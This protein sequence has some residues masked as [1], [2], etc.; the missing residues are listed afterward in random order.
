MP[1]MTKIRESLGTFFLVFSVLF[2]VYMVLDWGMDITGRRR[3]DRTQSQEIGKVNGHEI[4]VK[5]FSDLVRRAADNQK[6]QTGSEPDEDQLKNIREQVWN[7]LV[8]DILYE[9]QIKR[10]GITVT[11][12]EIIDW[13][14]GNDPPAFLKQQFTDSTGT[15]NRQAYD[16][17][18][19]DPKNKAIMVSIESSLRKQREREKLQ[20]LVTTSIQT[21]E[22]EIRQRFIDQN[23][24]FNAGFLY[25]DPNV[26]VKDD[27]VKVTDDDLRRFYN[28]HSDEFKV[29]ATRK[30]KYIMFSNAPSHGDSESVVSALDDV[31]KRVTE[32]ADFLDLAKQ[33]SETPVSDTYYKHGDLPQDQENAIFAAKDGEILGPI[34]TLDGYHLIKVL[35]FRNG[36]NTAVHASHIL[37]SIQNN[38]SVTAL[39][40]AKDV[41]AQAKSGKDFAALAKQ[42]SKDPGSAARGGDV[43]WFGKGKMVPPFEQAAFKAGAGQ[44][45]GPVR[46]QFGYH[47]IKVL[48]KDS[49]EVKIAD[50]HMAVHMSSQTQGDISQRAQDFIYLAKQGSFEK[51]AEQSK[52][53]VQET[54]PFQKD[55]VVPGFG[56]NNTINKF[57]FN[58]KSGS[59]SDPITVQN[60]LAVLMVSEVKEAGM[61]SF[62]EVK[63]TLDARV[64]RDKKMEKTKTMVAGMRQS[65]AKGDSLGKIILTHT[66]I[67]AVQH[68]NDV[69]LGGFI[70]GVGRDLSFIGTLSQIQPGEISQPVESQRGIYLIQ[71]QNKTPFDSSAYTTQHETLRSQVLTEKRNRVLSEWTEDLKK[72]ADIVDNRDTF[73][74]E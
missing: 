23:V 16:A 37:I 25:F 36:S 9:D 43:G 64:K 45:V 34:Q 60:G 66:G 47:I 1:L 7:Q 38:D 58:N 53:R 17:T 42:Y 62:D 18:I 10:L 48:A 67:S 50:L 73:Y 33:E 12:Q 61:R 30:L 26:F 68:C 35:D 13:V 29:E 72:K 71:L 6:S 51:E 2:V 14:R 44:I 24:K 11:D 49:R 32:G 65:L 57:A 41:L 63:S 40:Q 15:F 3:G 22:T 74:R 39:K 69:T 70:P 28:E 5:D 46:T 21:D 27:D 56:L 20:S 52:Y 8:D 4:F 31:Q 19:M 54:L 59:I 55:A